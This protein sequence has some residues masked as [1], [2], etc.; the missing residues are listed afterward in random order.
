MLSRLIV[1]SIAALSRFARHDHV[2]PPQIEHRSDMIRDAATLNWRQ[3]HDGVADTL[4]L[5]T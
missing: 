2:E 3:L 4:A 5:I 1:A